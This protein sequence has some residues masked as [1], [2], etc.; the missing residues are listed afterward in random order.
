MAGFCDCIAQLP[1]VKYIRD[2]APNIT[3]HLWVPDYFVNL[4]KKLLPGVYIKSHTEAK[5]KFN[6]RLACVKMSN[7]QV[8]NF[9]SHMVDF[10]FTMI[11]NKQV[12]IQHKNY[13]SLITNTIDIDRFV[14]P[15][16]YVVLTIG[17]TAP[18][19]E[20][21]P[22]VANGI[23]AHCKSK[24]MPVVLLGNHNTP[25]GSGH[26]IIGKFKEEINYD[27]TINLI[28]KT[29]L[30]EAGAIIAKSKGLIGL[31]NGLVHLAACTEVPIVVA[32]T[33]V[34]KEHRLPI[35]HNELGWNC[36]AIEPPESLEC[37]GCQSNMIHVYN[38]DFRGCYYED[39][40]PKCVVSITA[41]KYIEHI[42]KLI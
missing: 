9:S 21:L 12:D 39:P 3:I 28:G 5:K 19:R 40:I 31:D 35:R 37:R 7:A 27:D 15:D 24:N 20:M 29:N 10:A 8:N 18:V 32:Y 25:T 16:K 22:S 11:V 30:L 17:Y 14:L 13:L 41:D 4:A 23:I 1:A 2:N 6:P 36:Y 38:F 26:V 42:D 33:S 34:I